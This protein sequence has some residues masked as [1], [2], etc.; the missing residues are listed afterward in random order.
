MVG[1]KTRTLGKM[2]KPFAIFGFVWITHHISERAERLCSRQPH[3]S[4]TKQH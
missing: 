4:A 1:M 3:I 2:I